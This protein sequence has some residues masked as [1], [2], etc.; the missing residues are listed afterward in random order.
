MGGETCSL[1]ERPG[2]GK[3]LLAEE[4]SWGE[5]RCSASHWLPPTCLPRPLRMGA[6]QPQEE[7]A[8]L[9]LSCP[10]Y[11]GKHGKEK[12]HPDRLVLDTQA[13]R[14][15][16]G[17]A[18]TPACACGHVCVRVWARVCARVGTC[19]LPCTVCTAHTIF[20]KETGSFFRRGRF[21]EFQLAVST[22]VRSI[23]ML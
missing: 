12:A 14:S 6:R 21:F 16:E 11:H 10:S 20:S 1:W 4:A 23:S 13:R 7:R 19:V 3:G 18:P 2:W 15:G 9:R 17:W 22:N 5:G 8:V